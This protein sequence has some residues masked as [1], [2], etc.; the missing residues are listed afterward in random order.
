[1][2][3]PRSIPRPAMFP[4]ARP[5]VLTSREEGRITPGH[6]HRAYPD[7]DGDGQTDIIAS[8]FHYIRGWK[9]VPS[10]VDGHTHLLTTSSCGA[11][12]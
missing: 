1:M 7:R 4:M 11:G 2:C 3:D 8:H 10:P 12:R 6:T 5:C 9:V